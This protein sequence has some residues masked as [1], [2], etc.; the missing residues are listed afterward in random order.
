MGTE[1]TA[2]VILSGGKLI[3]DANQELNR[4]IISGFSQI[5]SSI[6]DSASI[7]NGM[8]QS[9]NDV[10][11]TE[12]DEW[13]KKENLKLQEKE[14]NIRKD[15]LV[16]KTEYKKAYLES[17]EKKSAKQASLAPLV[18]AVGKEASALEAEEKDLNS[19]LRLLEGKI[20]GFVYDDKGKIQM[21]GTLPV[22]KGSA[23][24][25]SI[26]A[27]ID[28][29][30]NRKTSIGDRRNKITGAVTA[31]NLNG[32][33]DQ[34][35]LELYPE[36]QGKSGPNP[37][38]PNANWN[39]QDSEEWNQVPNGDSPGFEWLIDR[40]KRLEGRTNE[41]NYPSPN[42]DQF[43][44]VSQS[45]DPTNLGKLINDQFT[46]FQ[47]S[48]YYSLNDYESFIDLYKRNSENNQPLPYNLFQ[49]MLGQMNP[50]DQKK[51]YG[52]VDNV[53]KGYAISIGDLLSKE[54]IAER[55]QK[56][57]F[58][59]I[60]DTYRS[61]MLNLGVDPSKL[62]IAQSRVRQAIINYKVTNE[63]YRKE[64]DNGK[65]SEMISD[66]IFTNIGSI[67]GI[68]QLQ[69][70]KPSNG[71]DVPED[72]VD[73]SK[74]GGLELDENGIPIFKSQTQQ[75]QDSSLI[76][77]TQNDFIN[78]FIS[79]G[80]GMSRIPNPV[81]E[82]YLEWI[83]GFKTPQDFNIVDSDIIGDE[84]YGSVITK[85]P[86]KEVDA[87]VNKKIREII[88]DPQQA[89]YFWLSKE[90]KDIAEKIPGFSSYQ[91]DITRSLLTQ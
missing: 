10:R 18:S 40:Q 7:Y 74:Y 88:N 47:Q 91:K 32:D 83:S 49:Q 36:V 29:I 60:E 84:G 67:L 75:D 90:K 3:A 53:L 64:Q 70:G 76:T 62:N 81:N 80:G 22:R 43:D 42:K 48:Q 63:D 31:I 13:Y 61:Q 59:I 77:K 55:S 82:A 24:Y 15:A 23:D 8:I 20:N 28:A 30:K 73:S 26:Q 27:Q 11:R 66:Y 6:K 2:N 68:E 12:I 33:P 21:T 71:L 51:I 39:E 56:N 16:A 52:D 87:M 57:E 1:N 78:K 69:E 9:L 5:Q 44:V 17:L 38:L 19:Q 85:R 35:R 45:N 72:K 89:Y 86:Q 4:S 50:D 37:L 14:L 46:K 58:G 79:K 54:P 65:R 25:D 41:Q 34:V